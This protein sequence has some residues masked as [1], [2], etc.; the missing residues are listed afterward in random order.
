AIVAARSQQEG[1]EPPCSWVDTVAE[2]GAR[3]L[4]ELPTDGHARERWRATCLQPLRGV[5][6]LSEVVA[7]GGGV[8]V[9]AQLGDPSWPSSQEGTVGLRT[10]TDDAAEGIQRMRVLAELFA[11]HAAPSRLCN[12]L[13]AEPDDR[14]HDHR[15]R[16]LQ[17]DTA[18]AICR[19]TITS[20]TA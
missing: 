7:T 20:T 9:V 8:D 10:E 16:Q 4:S 12:A 19:H 6:G 5:L 17:V 15:S 3:K 13:P 2:A 18:P 1:I 11:V 14:Y